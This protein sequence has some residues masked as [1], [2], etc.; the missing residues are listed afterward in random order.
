V[1]VDVPIIRSLMINVVLFLAP[2]LPWLGVLVGIGWLKRWHLMWDVALSFL[3]FAA[4]VVFAYVAGWHVS[5]SPLWNFTWTVTTIGALINLLAG[6]SPDYGMP[7]QVCRKR[8]VALTFCAAYVLFFWGATRVV[9]PQADHDLDLQ[10]TAYALLNRLTPSYV[11]PRGT[12]Y[13]A[14]PPL[15]HL[16]VA[17][18]FLYFN[19]LNQLDVFDPSSARHIALEA[20][21]LHYLQYPFFL[22]TR[23]PNIF[24]GAVTITSLAI[25]ISAP[26]GACIGLL[27]AFA[28]ATLPEMLVRFSYGGYFAISN[29]YALQMVLA[30]EAWSERQD[31]YGRRATLAIGAFAAWAN[32]KLVLLPMSIAVW[33]AIA[34]WPPRRLVDVTA[35]VFH[36][37]VVGFVL[38]SVAFWAYGLWVSPTDFWNDHVRHHIVDRMLNASMATPYTAEYP[39]IAS[40]W[41]EFWR[42]TSFLFLPLGAVSVILLIM[43]QKPAS[44]ANG[45]VSLPPTGWLGLPG[46]VLVWAALSATA[47]SL[48]DWRQT[49]HLAEIFALSQ[50]IAPALALRLWPPY[51]YVVAAVCLAMLTWNAME[52]LQLL[53]DFGSLVKVPEW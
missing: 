26:A 13:L 32:H 8:L 21:E 23:T 33:N 34:P 17:G 45:G 49:K 22:E 35:R 11:T 40:L 19:A 15:L 37:I 28:F 12:N 18:S 14:H 6:G 36:P 24:L 30:T 51:R 9:P 3:V 7:L 43:L 47:F 20:D 38:G 2:G 52:I 53:T 27:L 25:W 4:G 1:I 31:V 29:F 48:I 5:A 39:G 50:I 16:Y 41:Y 10:G 44:L 46:L 42:D